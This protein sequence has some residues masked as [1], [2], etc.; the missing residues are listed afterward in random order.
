MSQAVVVAGGAGY[1]GSA[2]C[3]QLDKSGFSPV[4]I[5]DLSTGSK[6]AVRWGPLVQGSI[7]DTELVEGVLQEFQPVGVIHL[8]ANAYV[9]ES[10]EK[11]FKYFQNNVSNSITFLEVL[12]RYPILPVVFSSSCATYGLPESEKISENQIQ[13]PVNPYGLSKLIIEQVLDS[14]S[15]LGKLK[16]AALRYF[17]AAGASDDC[18]ISEKHDPETHAIPLAVRSAI[19]GEAF[20]IFGTDYPTPDGSAVRDFVHVEDLAEAHVSALRYLT[21]TGESFAANLGT[22]RGSSVREVLETLGQLGL[23]VSFTE[24]DRRPGDPPSLVADPGMAGALLHWNPEKSDLSTILASEVA[25]QRA[26]LGL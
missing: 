1:V 2:V 4:V 26:A 20:K 10:M 3:R 9:G 7:Q 8:A 14:L 21:N 6:E 17:N 24:E 5:D 25:A 16:F 12:S 22:G 18:L 15:S 23:Q 19:S 11:P 13:K